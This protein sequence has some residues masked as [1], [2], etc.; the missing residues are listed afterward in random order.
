MAYNLIFAPEVYS[1]LQGS[2]NWYNER[3]PGLGLRF[4]RAVKEQITQIRKTP[5]SIAVRYDDVR[6]SKVKGFPYMIHFVF[7]PMTRQIKIIAVFSMYRDP[8]IWNERT[9]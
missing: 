6:C 8:K 2:I 5:L 3:K 7:S 4:F 1:D 9:D